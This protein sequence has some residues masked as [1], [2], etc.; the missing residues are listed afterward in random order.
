[1]GAGW[2]PGAGTGPGGTGGRVRGRTAPATGGADGA[3]RGWGVSS[4]QA[5]ARLS[6]D[7]AVASVTFSPDGRWLATGSGDRT[8]RVWAEGARAN[9]ADESGREV[10]SGDQGSGPAFGDG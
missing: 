10:A 3:A 6:H 8:V 7:D 4:G 1:M 5:L 2:P 9:S